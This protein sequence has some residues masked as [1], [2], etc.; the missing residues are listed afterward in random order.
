MKSILI[1]DDDPDFCELVKT[2]LKANNYEVKESYNL[3]EAMMM[4]KE[5]LP[6]LI[7]L[8]LELIKENGVDFLKKRAGSALLQTIPVIVCS[9]HNTSNVVLSAVRNGADDYIIKPITPEMLLERVKKH[10][11]I[12]EF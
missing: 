6:D 9:N 2:I 7:L 10:T 1:I 12:A 3:L 4:M 11:E 8:D 5:E